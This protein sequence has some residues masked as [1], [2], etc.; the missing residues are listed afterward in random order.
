MYVCLVSED[1]TCTSTM[2]RRFRIRVQGLRPEYLRPARR[3]YFMGRVRVAGRGSETR[4]VWRGEPSVVAG[5][6]SDAV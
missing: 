6:L 2:S 1:P 3:S 5:T 4:T